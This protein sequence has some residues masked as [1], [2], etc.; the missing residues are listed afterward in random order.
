MEYNIK[1]KENEWHCILNA[2]QF[3]KEKSLKQSLKKLKKTNY[4]DIS[5]LFVNEEY[6]NTYI[7]EQT[8]TIDKQIQQIEKIYEK[9]TEKM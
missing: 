6:F 4:K 9:I 3:F 2:L 7:K 8:D 5:G 1:L